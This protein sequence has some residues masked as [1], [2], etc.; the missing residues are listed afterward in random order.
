MLGCMRQSTYTLRGCSGL[1]LDAVG[2]SSDATL[3]VAYGR[4]GAPRFSPE[5]HQFL[6]KFAKLA[7]RRLRCGA[8]KNTSAFSVLHTDA[9]LP[10]KDA[11][12]GLGCAECHPVRG[13]EVAI[14]RQVC[15]N[16]VLPRVDVGP[17]RF[18]YALASWAIR[19]L[20][21]Q[22]IGHAISLPLS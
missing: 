9:A 1:K 17:E 12:G 5:G 16:R 19:G 14:R 15:T 18:G 2:K 3:K 6:A 11:D 13:H 10:F 21:S 7:G 20:I 22:V 4:D 8:V